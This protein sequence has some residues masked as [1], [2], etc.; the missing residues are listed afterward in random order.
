MCV[1]L[2]DAIIWETDYGVHCH[3]RS[4]YPRGVRKLVQGQI[5]EH[6]EDR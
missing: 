2:A 3:E 5:D 6:I 1:R 4:D